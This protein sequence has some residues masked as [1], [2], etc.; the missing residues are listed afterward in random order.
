GRWRLLEFL[1]AQELRLD[2]LTLLAGL[3]VLHRT[4][5]EDFAEVLLADEELA[6]SARS[7]FRDHDADEEARHAVEVLLRPFF[8]GV[9]VAAGAL[10]LRAEKH[11]ADLHS[12]VLRRAAELRQ[13]GLAPFLLREQQL[14]HPLVVGDVLL[15][16]ASQPLF[17][18]LAAVEQV[19][20]ARPPAEESEVP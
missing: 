18:R 3:L 20:A 7:A 14:A 6:I 19:A 9:I 10:Q 1:A 11:P 16:L 13:I 12:R 4:G 2:R 15:K 17:E 5:E 8:E